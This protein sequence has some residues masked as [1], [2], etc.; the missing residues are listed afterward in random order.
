MNVTTATLGLARHQ[1]ANWIVDRAASR[2]SR[3]LPAARKA[4]RYVQRLR[5]EL[6]RVQ[7]LGFHYAYVEGL[8][9]GV[10]PSPESI[11]N[12]QRRYY[13]LLDADWRG[14][15]LGA[16]PWS[17]L[18]SPPMARY[19]H[20]LPMFLGELPRLR[21][22]AQA[23]RHDDLP[24]LANDAYPDYYTRCFHWQSDG[25]LSKR[26]AQLYDM[27]VELLFLGC[28]DV[29]RRQVLAAIDHRGRRPGARLLD[30]ACGTG[31][32]LKAAELSLP[33]A[34][35]HG[36]DLSPFYVDH[37]RRS[38]S[39]TQVDVGDARTLDYPDASFDVVTS[40]YL[41]HEMPKDARRQA[42]AEALRVLKPGGQL[43]IEDA[44]QLSE[45]PELKEV[46]DR[47]H[48]RLHEPYFKGYM[49]DPIELILRDAGAENVRVRE[50]FVAKVVSADKPG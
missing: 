23:G 5:H 18:L 10:P 26:S 43:V 17:L 40:V 32:F 28:A 29:M 31:R 44:A 7:L 9:S 22:R 50:C 11:R 48:R 6:W 30:I 34:N 33:E 41:L 3:E 35:L 42:V 37:A 21:R 39:R 25:Y 49:R 38:L 36:V 15:E 20:R 2:S 16:Y 4:L 27:E 14:A 47:F 12:V 8:D 45:S 46:L 13:R 19:L 1:L 24:E